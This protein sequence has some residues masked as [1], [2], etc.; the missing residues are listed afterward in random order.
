MDPTAT[1]VKTETGTVA[2]APMTLSALVAGDNTNAARAIEFGWDEIL[3]AAA[4]IG[5]SSLILASD[6]FGAHQRWAR[7]GGVT[8]TVAGMIPA[9]MLMREY[10]AARRD[11]AQG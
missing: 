1:L 3:G 4:I 9:F 10:R 2:N 7:L 5:G 8:L 11:A 6:V